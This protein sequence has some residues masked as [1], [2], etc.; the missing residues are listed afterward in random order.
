MSNIVA[1]GIIAII[2]FSLVGGKDKVPDTPEGRLVA[3]IADLEKKYSAAQSR[4]NESS[5]DWRSAEI[6][7]EYDSIVRQGDAGASEMLILAQKQFNN[8]MYS[9]EQNRLK[10]YNR[11][12]MKRAQ[13]QVDELKHQLDIKRAQLAD[14]KRAQQPVNGP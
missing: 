13:V 8:P 2:F 1:I 11:D 4:Y 14:I 12:S 6:K 9:Q 3:E 10:D 7:Q 5:S